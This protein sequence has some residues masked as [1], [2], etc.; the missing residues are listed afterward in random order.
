M[1]WTDRY[2]RADADGAGNGTT[3]ANSGVNG[4]WTWAQ[5]LSTAAAGQRV[6]AL[7]GSYSL[8]NGNDTPTN[9]GTAIAPIWLRGFDTT[10]DQNDDE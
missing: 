3:N 4:A 5:V 8:G 2:L 9:A 7:K 10:I 6:N 1:A